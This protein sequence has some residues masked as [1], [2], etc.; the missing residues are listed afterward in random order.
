[1]E[2]SGR[3]LF[4]KMGTDPILLQND[5]IEGNWANGTKDLSLISYT[6]NNND[7]NL[8]NKECMPEKYGQGVFY[9]IITK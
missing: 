3:I 2:S 4:V 5:T 6:W 7:L 1:M 9:K 8:K